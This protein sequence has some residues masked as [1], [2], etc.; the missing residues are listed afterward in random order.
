[1]KG[2]VAGLILIV[3]TGCA[4]SGANDS[5][6]PNG[7]PN[8]PA[9]GAPDGSPEAAD[10]DEAELP[11]EERVEKILTETT[12]DDSY[13]TTR[14][15]INTRNLRLTVIDEQRIAFRNRRRVWL[16]ELKVPCTGL[17][18]SSILQFDSS[19]GGLCVQ[20][21]IQVVD[22]GNFIAGFC[23]LGEFSEISTQQLEALKALLK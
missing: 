19:T 4:G 15:C 2:L 16:N 9:A 6:G 12:D 20:D 14:N 17:T 21:R 7:L 10:A 8:D 18:R 23:L 13:G 3:L 1:M 5:G 22:P 11:L